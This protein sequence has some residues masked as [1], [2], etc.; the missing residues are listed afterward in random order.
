MG[1][2]TAEAATS[3]ALIERGVCRE[4]VLIDKNIARARGVALDMSYALPCQRRSMSTPAI[5]TPWSMRSW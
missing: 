4:L 2:K 3:L 1:L 5:T